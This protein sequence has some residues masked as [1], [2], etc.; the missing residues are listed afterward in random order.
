[1]L[2]MWLTGV[3]LGIKHLD[4]HFLHQHLHPLATNDMP[5]LAQHP[6]AG[7]GELQMPSSIWRISPTSS[8]EI[9][10]EV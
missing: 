4:A 5:V 7:E 6:A 8:G 3:G 10:S 1:M 9:G 2:G